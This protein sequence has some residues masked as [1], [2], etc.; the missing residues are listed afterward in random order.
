MPGVTLFLLY[1]LANLLYFAVG[2]VVMESLGNRV[3]EVNLF[4]G[5]RILKIPWRGRLFSIG[6]FPAGGSIQPERPL[7][8][9]WGF[10]KSSLPELASAASF[11][12]AGIV[13]LGPVPA[14]ESLVHGLR[15]FFEG[16]WSPLTSGRR[17]WAAIF[18]FMQ[19]ASLPV[20]FGAV[21]IKML[22][23]TL[24]PLPTGPTGAVLFQGLARALPSS[25]GVI[26]YITLCGV[27]AM[28]IALCCWLI[29]LAA[30]LIGGP[31]SP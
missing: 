12:V 25:R 8:E 4:F 28:L 10:W 31:P 1:L 3:R 15:Q 13:L 27:L 9:D 29:A 2:A 30:F 20:A 6:I 11:A 17:H 14:W 7:F 26:H 22:A 5:R 21:A 23:P 19:T 18:D 16:A 24:L